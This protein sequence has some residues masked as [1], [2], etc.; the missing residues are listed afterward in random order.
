M[1]VTAASPIADVIEGRGFR[2]LI[3]GELTGAEGGRTAWTKD[4]STGRDIAEVPDATAADVNRAV[5]AGKAAQPEWEAI[6]HDGRAACF[7]E[8]YQRLEER[9]DELALIDSIDSGNPYPAM[10][11]D[12]RIS[13][14]NVRDWPTLVRWHG[15]R[16][17][18]ATRTGLHYTSR[19]PYGVVARILA[20]NHPLMFAITRPLSALIAGCTVVMKPS[21]QTPLGA[22]ALAEIARDVFPPGVLNI[23]TGGVEPGD[24]LV[25]HRDIRRI[26]FTG[27][28]ATGMK[29]QQRAAEFGIK[30]LSLELGGKNPMIVLPDVDLDAAVT[31]A[32]LGM[33]FGICQGQS[34]GSNSRLYV[35]RDIYEDFLAKAGE[36]LEAMRVAPAY[37][38]E[39][40]MGPLVTERHLERVLSY[41]DA[42][43]QEGA[44]LIT[45]GERPNGG[46]VPEGGYFLRPTLFADITP[47]M[48]ITREEIFGPVL[49]AA[50]WDDL[51]DVIEKANDT[52]LGLTGSVWTSDLDIAH[53]VADRLEAGY[54]WINES[55][56]HFWGTPFGGWKNSGVGREESTEE[57]DSFF[58][59]KVVHTM[60]R[61]PQAA[62]DR[63][64]RPR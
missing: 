18:P 30:H 39:V 63:L 54:V 3:G 33:N 52:D 21:D 28:V 53:A 22:L 41:V 37:S 1:S 38:D 46:S 2:M 32:I 20:F 25:T 35:H 29:I 5:A 62:F 40:D 19:R 24:A 47:D 15:G 55:S 34:C 9:L 48:R 13:L 43:R 36:R 49:S 58:E 12:M 44:R 56:K 27:S 23:V 64:V 7:A 50:V 10:R 14:Q 6:G 4:P 17:I 45:G 60:L 42:G 16:T 8:L 59:H 31:G 26:G 61:D 57:Y 51:E 11:N